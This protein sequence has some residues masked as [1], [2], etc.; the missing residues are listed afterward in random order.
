[1]VMDVLEKKATTSVSVKIKNLMWLDEQREADPKFTFSKFVDNAIDK[2][3][4][5]GTKV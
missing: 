5:G 2:E 4:K 1:M 3:R